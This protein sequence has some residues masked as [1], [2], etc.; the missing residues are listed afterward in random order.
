MTN[1]YGLESSWFR[2]GYTVG[3]RRI[4]VA[5]AALGMAGA[6]ALGASGCDTAAQIS[7][8]SR[9]FQEIH[10][11]GFTA[12]ADSCGGVSGGD[13]KA[14]FVLVDNKRAPIR[15]G[16]AIDRPTSGSVSVELDADS[17]AFSNSALME[18]TPNACD[19][20]DAA[21][22][23]SSSP[24]S[25]QCKNAPG[26]EGAPGGQ[27]L[28]ACLIPEEG[29]TVDSG[30][31]GV[32]FVSDTSNDQVYGLLM[33]NSGGLKGWSLPGTEGA[34]DANGNGTV[35][36]PEDLTPFNVLYGDPIATDPKKKRVQGVLG[37]YSRWVD[38]Y[39]L[40]RETKR[41]TYF[42]LW[43]FNS[44]EVDPTSHI[45]AVGRAGRP[46]A[47]ESTPISDAIEDYQE[48]S[49]NQRS[50]ANIYEAALGLIEDSY[51]TQAMS[52]LGVA[53]P[54]N[55]DKVLVL[56]VD[57]YDDM[58]ENDGA[59]I[60]DVVT[61]ATDNNVRIFIVHVDPAFEEPNQIR[62][63]PTYWVGQQACESDSDCKN[64]ESCRNPKGYAP[65]VSDPVNEPDGFDD[66]YCLP[67]RDENGRVGP[68]Q[69]F[70][71]LACATEG[72]YMYSPSIDSVERNINWTPYALDG[73]WEATVGSTTLQRNDDLE[74][75][76]LKIHSDMGITVAGQSRNYA[77]TQL[78]DV[79][80]V[81]NA[82]VEAFDTRG[83][84]FTAE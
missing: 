41:K 72:G 55:V 1:K 8:S 19:N 40:A 36:E 3:A 21:S 46:W 37:A 11:S 77:F 35:G 38:A 74:G 84:V 22:E 30:P 14:R 13:M 10:S 27:S 7:F 44:I 18:V 62:E 57:G 49:I 66:T 75:V 58:R 69:D 80:S 50:R 34:W 28:M 56:F 47:S 24:V 64:F 65:S 60:D 25:F 2:T 59:S 43:S 81:A 31:S 5:V 73:L 71:R 29:L 9:T 82:K 54:E 63:D 70:S 26:L 51:S 33:E 4:G 45:E 15:L 78:G 53:N 83:V 42:G 32:E 23:C 6:L 79:V 76:P 48:T 52:D 61:A 39:Q 17:V 12:T 68:V 20:G 67:K 16:D